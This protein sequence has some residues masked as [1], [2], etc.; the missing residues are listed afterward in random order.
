MSQVNKEPVSRLEGFICPD[1]LV[2]FASASQVHEHWVNFHSTTSR[3][4][5]NSAPNVTKVQR[6]EAIQHNFKARL[7]ELPK[8][9]GV[10]QEVIENKGLFCDGCNSV[11]HKKCETMVKASCVKPLAIPSN[12]T[13][14]QIDNKSDKYMGYRLPKGQ[15]SPGTPRGI[16]KHLRHIV[17]KGRVR[18]VDKQFDLDLTYINDRVIAMSFPATGLETTYRNNLRDVAKLLQTNHQDKY[19]VFNLSERRY[20][21]SKLNNQVLD[22]GWPDHLAPP[23]ERLYSIIKSIDSWLKTDPQHVVVVHCKGGKGRT[24]VVISAYMHFSK[25]CSSPEAALDWFAMK[26]FYDDKLGGVTQPSQRRYVHYFSDYLDGKI[27]LSSDPIF[28]HHVIVHGIPNFDGKEG[29]KPFLRV[30]GGLKL[31]YTSGVF[32]VTQDMERICIT[33]E[34]GLILHGDVMIK[35]FHKNTLSS[36]GDIIFRCQFHTG[37]IKDYS[38]VL[39]KS[40]L[41]EAYR[42]KRF[43]DN[44]KVEFVF[45]SK[46]NFVAE[47]KNNA[48]LQSIIRNSLQPV[49]NPD[50]VLMIPSEDC[51]DEEEWG[52]SGASS[53]SNQ[54]EM[55]DTQQEP[56]NSKLNSEES[57]IGYSGHSSSFS[58]PSSYIPGPLDGSLYAQVDKKLKKQI[59]SYS[60]DS[61]IHSR[62]SNGVELLDGNAVLNKG[63]EPK[64]DP[65]IPQE[66]ATLNR[67]QYN[68]NSNKLNSNGDVAMEQDFGGNIQ[69]IDK[70]LKEL[71]ECSDLLDS[72]IQQG[73]NKST[74]LTFEELSSAPIQSAKPETTKSLNPPTPLRRTASYGATEKYHE[75][76]AVPAKVART[77][78]NNQNGLDYYRRNPEHGNNW[79]PSSPQNTS[80]PKKLHQA[81]ALK[82]H[83]RS[84]SPTFYASK[85]VVPYKTKVGQSYEA[86]D[87]KPGVN[88]YQDNDILIGNA[89][90]MFNEHNG[91]GGVGAARSDINNNP[92]K[93]AQAQNGTLEDEELRPEDEIPKKGT[94]AAKVAYLTEIVFPA[95]PPAPR[96]P[97]LKGT[98]PMPGLVS[99]SPSDISDEISKHNAKSLAVGEL[100][101]SSN[102]LYIGGRPQKISNTNPG[103][104][105]M[106]DS[107]MDPEFVGKLRA[108]RDRSDSIE[109]AE[110]A[111]KML[112][113]RVTDKE[114]SDEG[115][116]SKADTEE[117]ETAGSAPV[118]V[119][120]APREFTIGQPIT[121][122]IPA[123]KS[124]E[125][126][127]GEKTL[128][129]TTGLL[130]EGRKDEDDGYAH[131][132]DIQAAK[133]T[134]R[135]EE[136][137]PSPIVLSKDI[138]NQ[139]SM[140]AVLSS[141]PDQGAPPVEAHAI[142]GILS[143]MADME[144]EMP[145]GDDIPGD[146]TGR[147]A[148]PQ[149]PSSSVS[150]PFDNTPRKKRSPYHSDKGYGSTYSLSSEDSSNEVFMD[151]PPAHG[152]KFDKDNSQFWY[153]PNISRE[154]AINI[155]RDKE[156]GYFVVRDSQSFP[157]AYGLAVKVAV[158]P[159]HV[160]QGD[161]TKVD[162]SSELIRHF[163]IEST[164]KGVKLKGITN[165]PV[166]GSLSAF[167][168]QHTITPL[169]LPIRLVIPSED[170]LPG[171]DQP[172]GRVS[173]SSKSPTTDTMKLMFVGECSV[174]ML[175]GTSAIQKTVESL[176]AYSAE[177]KFTSASFR[178]TREGITITDNERKVFFRK[179]FPMNNVLYCGIDPLDHRWDLKLSSYSGKSRTFGLVVRKIGEIGNECHLFAE[180]DTNFPINSVVNIVNKF[181]S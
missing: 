33:I 67:Y 122:T 57:K 54:Q 101:H 75:R 23:L 124:Q 180:M 162:L 9:C 60:L 68:R 109:N 173:S 44:C 69:S 59:R 29:C 167:I 154:Q 62:T 153:K 46:G 14:L 100:S 174:E 175:S 65:R 179:H 110:I 97:P 129:S 126:A 12:S 125:P 87:E 47:I 22:F 82:T 115:V 146:N 4:K 56:L 53:S 130:R 171:T 43:A 132:E 21:I 89:P 71:G 169:S 172:D 147:P 10:C 45:S 58:G 143:E 96:N 148:T 79:S 105:D 119:H 131:V 32:Y 102:T 77:Q 176:L 39:D 37:A 93:S 157:G 178:V 78:S 52:N 83:E 144:L 116:S 85:V 155:L 25:V 48:R 142:D 81:P 160:L 27:K 35:C 117:S 24:G 15:Q 141:E 121:F 91:K 95:L 8:K 140:V 107:E 170:L 106:S 76:H 136:S 63:Y 7:F 139:P 135:M 159:P 36:G 18:H 118:F 88:G 133:H 158:P 20:D 113:D 108:A 19:M 6:A 30:Y 74:P 152:V 156:P 34:G 73:K 28:L 64:H 50:T 149:T 166:F 42:D 92:P 86:G 120:N 90:V 151:S 2:D 181:I 16:V 164:K 26:R 134:A 128:D 3:D 150:G 13:H 94:V 138:H 49:E 31:I 84:L 123:E 111:N 5:P 161:L 1:C 104:K 163:L 41:D 114:S 55:S 51:Q 11:C 98:V 127:Q 61:G 177:P 145:R 66:T 72:T 112:A 17:S 70:L 165:E 137:R 168:F 103:P 80:T 40:E 99:K 38:L